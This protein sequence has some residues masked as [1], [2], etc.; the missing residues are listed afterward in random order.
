MVWHSFVYS[1]CMCVCVFF[2]F[3][4]L[5]FYFFSLSTVSCFSSRA[6]VIHLNNCEE[7][8]LTILLLFRSKY[9][10]RVTRFHAIVLTVKG[11]YNFSLLTRIPDLFMRC[12]LTV[13]GCF[14]F[15]SGAIHKLFAH[16]QFCAI[17]CDGVCVCVCRFA[18]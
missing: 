11:P 3:S 16:D 5:L 13:R 4:F 15:E 2:S 10:I 7:R 12:V 6:V 17:V 9:G 8:K 1:V 14:H 18:T